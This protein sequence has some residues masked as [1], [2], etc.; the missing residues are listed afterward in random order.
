MI[1]LAHLL[2]IIESVLGPEEYQKYLANLSAELEMNPI[3][4]GQ[5]YAFIG[6]IEG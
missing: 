6:E 3:Q 2:S 4:D 1:D 5:Y